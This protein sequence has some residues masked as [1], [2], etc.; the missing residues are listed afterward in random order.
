MSGPIQYKHVVIIFYEMIFKLLK[1]VQRFRGNVIE[2]Q[3]FASYVQTSSYS[4]HNFH[5]HVHI[6][7]SVFIA[8]L[9]A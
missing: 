3:N 5:L 8:L 4:N 1:L 7:L 6:S 9:I 2:R